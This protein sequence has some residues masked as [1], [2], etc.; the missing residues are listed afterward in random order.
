MEFEKKTWVAPKIV[1]L[2]VENTHGG[3]TTQTHE[4]TIGT[5]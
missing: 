2:T 4:S 3:N 1:H 5:S